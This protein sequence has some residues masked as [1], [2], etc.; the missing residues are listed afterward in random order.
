MVRGET[1]GALIGMGQ[2]YV[3]EEV[4]D[5]SERSNNITYYVTAFT[6]LPSCA[7]RSGTLNLQV[8]A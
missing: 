3:N 6:V 7:S 8:N 1:E 4:Y 2:T 5:D